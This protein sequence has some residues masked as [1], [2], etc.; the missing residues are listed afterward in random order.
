MSSPTCD[1]FGRPHNFPRSLPGFFSMLGLGFEQSWEIGVAL[2]GVF[3]ASLAGLVIL[4]GTRAWTLESFATWALLVFSPPVLLLLER[5]NTD[6]LVFVLLCCGAALM[7]T[8][9]P[10]PRVIAS[11]VLIVGAQAKLMPIAASPG[12][13]NRKV[14]GRVIA[15]GTLIA[16]ISLLIANLEESLLVRERTPS[17]LNIGFGAGVIPRYIAEGFGLGA[18]NVELQVFGVVFVTLALFLADRTSNRIARLR[19]S[20]SIADLSE[21]LIKDSKSRALVLSGAGP[22]VFVYLLGASYDYRLSLLA[23][24]LLAMIRLANLGIIK[25][26]TPSYWLVSVMWLSYNMAPYAQ[27]VGDIILFA[28]MVAFLRVIGVVLS[29]DFR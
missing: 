23:L 8:S 18:G 9:S 17:P 12:L 3:C 14:S 11:A 13:L 26:A 25:S 7:S 24:P 28:I 2:L 29:A 27:L 1:P 21:G 5:G 4:S 20:V 6:I 10:I 19:S 15:I 16:G 22:L